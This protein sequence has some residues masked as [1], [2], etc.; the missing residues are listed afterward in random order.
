[1]NVTE[2]VTIGGF[3]LTIGTVVAGIAFLHGRGEEWR[4]ATRAALDDIREQLNSD[5]G[6]GFV[7]RREIELLKEQADHEHEILH[8]RIR[9]IGERTHANTE[10]LAKHDAEIQSLKEGA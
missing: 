1:M 4:A 5:G 3:L 2:I 9:S 8:G 10:K 6:M 7:R